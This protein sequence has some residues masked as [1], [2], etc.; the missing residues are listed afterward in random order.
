MTFGED[1]GCGLQPRGV[2]EDPRH[3]PRPRRELRST[4]PTSTPTA[5]PRRSSATTSPPAP[6]GA[7][8]VVLASK[9]FGNMFPGD[10]NGGGAGRTAIIAAAGRDSLRRLRTDYLDLYWLHN[11]DRH[12]PIEE[13]M[14]TLDDLVRAGKIR[15]VGFSD[16]PAWVAAGR[17]PRAAARLVADHRDAGGVLAAGADGRRASWRRSPDQG[18]GADAVE[19]A[20]ER[21]PVRQVRE[22]PVADPAHRGFIGAH[23]REYDVIDAVTRDRRPRSAPA[24]PR[25]RWPGCGPAR[26]HL[27]DHRRPAAGASRQPRRA[28]H[29]AQPG[30]ARPTG[31]AVRAELAFPAPPT[32]IAPALEFGGMT[33]DGVTYPAHP[34]VGAASD[35]R[36][37][38]VT[39][40]GR[41]C[42]PSSSPPARGGPWP[43]RPGV[44]P[45]R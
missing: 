36:S 39:A 28:G 2:G 27:D 8:R 22:R 40:P 21:L 11:W 10:P 37:T 29:R 26:G 4:P 25:W 44:R 41:A 19:P 33:V 1:P 17:R 45:R 15:Y 31:Q 32:G 13:T 23:R 12:T 30:A 43:P 16:T 38:D 9:F 7:T 3:L 20:E 34:A 14:R 6:A 24:R 5:T 18:I 42:R 35:Q